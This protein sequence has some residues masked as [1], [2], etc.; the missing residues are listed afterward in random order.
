MLPR[1][2]RGDSLLSGRE[3]FASN[4]HLA[5]DSYKICW[6]WEAII[7]SPELLHQAILQAVARQ[8]SNGCTHRGVKGGMSF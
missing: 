6:E 5:G 2:E 3:N 4:W 8:F 1:L 7:P